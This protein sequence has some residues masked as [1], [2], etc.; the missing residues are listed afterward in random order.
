MIMKMMKTM[1]NAAAITMLLACG[2][3]IAVNNSSC[4][5]SP[6]PA[7]VK[8]VTVAAQQGSPVEGTAG[9]ATYTVATENIRSGRS[10]SVTWFTNSSG[11]TV[12]VAP[13][14][15]TASV[16]DVSDDAAAVTVNTTAATPAGVYY[17]KVAIDGA[18]SAVA[19][20]TVSSAPPKSVTVGEQTGSPVA[21]TANH[22]LFIITTENIA[23]ETEGSLAWFTD[24]TGTTAGSTPEGVSVTLGNV[25]VFSEGG[26]EISYAQLKLDT[27]AATPAGVYYFK[28]TFAGATSAVAAFT[29]SAVPVKI[30][31]VGTQQGSL[32]TGTAGSVTYAVT[33]ENIV[34]GHRGSAVWFDDA[35]GTI[36]RNTPP[37]GVNNS[38]TAVANNAATLTVT[39]TVVAAGTYY[40]RVVIDDTI[41]AVAT[42]TVDA[43]TVS[44]PQ[45]TMTST[46][47]GTVI[48]GLRGTGGARVDWGVSGV[49][50]TTITLIG[51]GT[52]T[53]LTHTYTNNI[54]RT[55]T[56]TGENI[57]SMTCINNALTTL[58]VNANT[59]LTTLSCGNNSLTTL[60]VS[61]LNSLVD[62]S[63]QDN[64]MEFDALNGL[65]SSLHS[66]G[67]GKRFYAGGN[68]GFSQIKYN[69]FKAGVIDKGW[70]NHDY[71][72]I[73]SIK[74]DKS[75]MTLGPGQ[76]AQVTV[77]ELLPMDATNRT[78]IWTSSLAGVTVSDTGLITVANNA[79]PGDA[80]IMAAA[81]GGSLQAVLFVVTVPPPGHELNPFKV[82]SAA[83]LQKVG[84]GT[85]GWG[86]DK[87][88]RQ[89][90]TIDLTN[91]ANWTPIGQNETNRFK[92]TYDGG[93]YAISGLFIYA[94]QGNN[95]GLFGVLDG[96]SKV[97]N[98][99]LSI[100]MK[101]TNP[102]AITGVNNV[103]GIAGLSWGTVE[104]CY[105]TGL[106]IRGATAVGGVVGNNH[107]PI[108]NCYSTVYSVTATGND[109][110]GIAG[111]QAS[112]GT[113]DN[114]YVTGR[115]EG[116]SYNIGGVVG[117]NNQGAIRNCVALNP[118]VQL[119]EYLNSTTPPIGRIVGRNDNGTLSNNHARADLRAKA[120]SGNPLMGYVELDI[121][122]GAT[123][124]HGVSTGSFNTSL[125]WSTTAGYSADVWDIASGRLP[126]L[127]GFSVGQNPVASVID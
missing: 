111:Y 16:D 40:F 121:P 110:G 27:T 90:A 13:A 72:L 87:H 59:A 44:G 4:V 23:A 20:F 74:I 75:D 26:V 99:G 36:R 12:H 34:N 24:E 78:V 98:V 95:K 96:G 114:C 113:I 10:G 21:G 68:P 85:D 91:V 66:G 89:T 118:L 107:G 48:I 35:A 28:V 71:V 54:Q 22:G 32:T 126:H 122:G 117:R 15:V 79:T 56:V 29:V 39:T 69:D 61:G 3:T 108:R 86:L 53:N 94:P 119:N 64:L 125:F 30:V 11:T 25:Y 33:T 47:S 2:A 49:A 8:T 109:L 9:S 14:G 116:S 41:S 115:V 120:Y 82:A 51:T 97:K 83:D 19:A 124:L 18:T 104:N 92:G 17:F 31:T 77:T 42:L 7:P 105:V 123:G 80:I 62:F 84:S 46:K 5:K 38:L 37:S 58:N 106:T 70:S 55:I 81:V 43:I 57:T 100:I 103:G 45:M 112:D 50:P 63:C 101:G 76:S 67:T 88:Y 60:S 6:K 1:K 73:S 65:I 52:Q 127:K 93:G 102:I